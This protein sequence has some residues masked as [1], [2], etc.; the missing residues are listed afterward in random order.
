[1]PE[2]KQH[3][4]LHYMLYS[5]RISPVAVFSLLI[6]SGL[7][8]GLV[9]SGHDTATLGQCHTHSDMTAVSSVD[10]PVRV[11]VYCLGHGVSSAAVLNMWTDC[12]TASGQPKVDE[13]SHNQN[14]ILFQWS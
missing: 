9:C 2:Q 11:V 10:C 8:V 4:K 3:N 12:S 1:M 5:P 6:T 13:Q 7:V 14:Y